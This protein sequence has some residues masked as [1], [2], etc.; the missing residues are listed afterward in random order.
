MLS[1]TNKKLLSPF[2]RLIKL[3]P[4]LITFLKEG[5]LIEAEFLGKDGRTLYFDLGKFG[6]GIVYGTEILNAKELVRNLKPGATIS[7][8]V[9][10]LE[11]ENHYIELS[12]V[13][14]QKQKNWQEIKNHKDSGEIIPVKIIGANSGGLVAKLND[15]KAFLPVSQLAGEHY[16]RVK[17]GEKGK[18]LEELRK[19]V[20][21]ELLVKVI[22]FNPKSEKLIISER[23]VVEENIK[24]LLSKY[25]EG[26]VIEGIISGIA[27]F[28][29]FMKFID[30]PTIEGMIHISELAHQLVENP[31]EVAKIDEPVKAKIVEIKDSRVSLSLK[32]LQP[33]PW[34][35]AGEKYKEGQEVSGKLNKFN[36]F[37]AFID[38]DPEIQGLIH[39]SEFG[40]IVE[41]MKKQLEPGKSYQFIIEALKPEEKRIILKMKK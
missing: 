39:I 13:S 32:A 18:I 3:E 40:G 17:E 28:G 5:D 2:A 21:Q 11:E 34:E 33:D 1:T 29:V 30:N 16:P 26:D 31:K 36:P 37:G 12:L 20:G 14:A 15:M 35:K 7:A 25:K 24:E 23:E 9:I 10:G 6:T 38:L 41:E 19:L 8:K 22:D 4:D 27:D